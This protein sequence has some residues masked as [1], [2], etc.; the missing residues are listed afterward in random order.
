M[1]V[2]NSCEK[3]ETCR[4]CNCCA[5]PVHCLQLLTIAFF[6]HPEWGEKIAAW[7]QKNPLKYKQGK[8]TIKP[9][10]VI[11]QIFEATCGEAIIATEVGQN[12]MWT[13]QFYGFH[14]PRTFLTSGGLG[15]MGYGFPAAIGA[16]VAYPDKTVF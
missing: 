7:S 14:K 12:Q 10:Y 2:D 5:A 4:N 8:N 16:Q 3:K 6:S 11:E 9:Q 1:R 13:A 15:T